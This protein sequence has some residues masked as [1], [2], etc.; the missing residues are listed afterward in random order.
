M[1]GH[2]FLKYIWKIGRSGVCITALHKKDFKRIK[3]NIQRYN[4]RTPQKLKKNH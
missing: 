1:E 4:L 2:E 3:N